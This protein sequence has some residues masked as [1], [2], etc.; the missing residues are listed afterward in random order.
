VYIYLF[1]HNLTNSARIRS[2][3]KLLLRNKPTM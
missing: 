1:H 3:A 2:N